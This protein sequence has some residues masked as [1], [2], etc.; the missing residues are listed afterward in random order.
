MF[1]NVHPINIAYYNGYGGATHFPIFC[2]IMG[3]YYNEASGYYNDF[4][5]YTANVK[6]DRY[7]QNNIVPQYIYTINK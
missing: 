7:H 3:K 5:A 6:L 1:F 4:I 2:R